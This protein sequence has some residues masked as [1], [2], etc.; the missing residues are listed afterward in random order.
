MKNLYLSILL[1]ATAIILFGTL[2]LQAQQR[3][4]FQAKQGERIEALKVGFF[5]K[6]LELSPDEAKAFWPLFDE[7][8]K[9]VIKHRKEKKESMEQ[10]AEKGMENMTD[11]ELNTLIDSRIR[12]AE[13]TVQARSAF[14]R[15]VRKVLPPRKV[16][17]FYKAEE[18]FNKMLLK[19][20]AEMR[21][22]GQ[23][24]PEE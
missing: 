9:T 1:T 5:T 3:R 12:Q 18:Q 14:F 16:I 11:E 2:E 20:A 6:Q 17:K 4:P 24:L 15:E 8:S 21:D 22:K 7:Y 19:K 23:Q 13:E 10:I